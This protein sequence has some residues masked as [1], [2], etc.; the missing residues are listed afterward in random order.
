MIDLITFFLSCM[1]AFG[2]VLTGAKRKDTSPLVKLDVKKSRGRDAEE[3]DKILQQ[4]PIQKEIATLRKFKIDTLRNFFEHHDIDVTFTDVTGLVKE[5]FKEGLIDEEICLRKTDGKQTEM[6]SEMMACFKTAKL[7]EQFEMRLQ[8]ET[9]EPIEIK[10]DDLAD[11]AKAVENLTKITTKIKELHTGIDS[12]LKSLRGKAKATESERVV[13]TLLDA[14]EEI[15]VS[16]VDLRDVPK[17]N[18][19]ELGVHCRKIL[20]NAIT[21]HYKDALNTPITNATDIAG[22]AGLEILTIFDA[23][24]VRALGKEP[25]VTQGI[26][27]LPVMVKTNSVRAK[28]KMKE[29][30]MSIAGY[31]ARDSIPKNFQVQRTEI[32]NTV[33]SLTKYKPEPVWIRVDLMSVRLGVEPTFK[34]STKNSSE[35]SAK[36][37]SIGTVMV[38]DPAMFGRLSQ[39]SIRENILVELHLMDE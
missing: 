1:M 11:P 17:S 18:A 28:E 37:E 27:T 30:I 3:I 4:K 14:R 16:G 15:L 2:D 10:T 26:T 9:V 29:A 12:D 8:I 33:K 7:E 39:D 31:K 13:K 32:H 19:Y 35:Q 6:L 38:R 34:V 22:N 21:M 36:W 5:L 24:E 23:S 20:R 25:K